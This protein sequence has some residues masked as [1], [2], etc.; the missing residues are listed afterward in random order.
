MRTVKSVMFH[1][2]VLYA[3]VESIAWGVVPI[4]L[5]GEKADVILL[6]TLQTMTGDGTGGV[7]AQ[8]QPISVL[9]GQMAACLPPQDCNCR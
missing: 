7:K 6:A 9:K 1:I 4:T 5:L 3:L 8:L 2:V